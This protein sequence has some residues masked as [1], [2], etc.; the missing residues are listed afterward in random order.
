MSLNA[1]LLIEVLSFLI[2]LGLLV[3]FLYRPVLAILDKRARDIQQAQQKIEEN[4]SIAEQGRSEAQRILLESKGE[5]LRIKE[6]IGRDA[7][8]LRRKIIGQAKEEAARILEA[9]RQDIRN[10]T[11]KAKE[12]LEAA[13]IELSLQGAEKI[14]GRKFTAADQRRL[15]KELTE[16]IDDRDRFSR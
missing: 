15:I 10:E 5:A 4:I 12:K 11:E 1:T 13:A 8:E 16:G 14:L 2:L 7:E 9:S 3:K 6:T